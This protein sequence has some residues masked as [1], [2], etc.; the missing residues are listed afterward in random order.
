[1]YFYGL[2]L[3]DYDKNSGDDT[4]IDKKEKLSYKCFDKIVDENVEKKLKLIIV[5]V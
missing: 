1:M 5:Q 4:D 3:I 2:P